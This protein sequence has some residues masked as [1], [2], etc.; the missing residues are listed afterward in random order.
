MTKK[1]FTDTLFK[2]M[3]EFGYRKAEIVKGKIFFYKEDT[4]MGVWVP[5]IPVESLVLQTNSNTLILANIQVLLIGAKYQLIHLYQLALMINYGFVDILLI[6]RMVLFIHGAVGQHRGV[7]LEENIRM[8]GVSQNQQRYKH[9][10]W[11]MLFCLVVAMG[12][13]NNSY[14]NAIIFVAWSVLVYMLAINGAFK[15]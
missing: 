11:F 5:R 13:V 2:A 3:Y 4:L 15:D 6:L 1:N 8:R 9:M 12:N 7:F 10:I 14:A